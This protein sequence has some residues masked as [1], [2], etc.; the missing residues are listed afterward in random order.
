VT[1]DKPTPAAKAPLPLQLIRRAIEEASD[2]SGWARLADVG[3]YVTKVK[4]DFDPRLHGHKKLSELLR[5]DPAHFTVEERDLAGGKK[6]L[7]VRA[8]G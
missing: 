5:S 6:V 1:A 8:A 7:Y 4:P 3:T 2:D